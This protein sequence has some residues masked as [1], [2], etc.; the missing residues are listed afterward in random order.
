MDVFFVFIG[1][2]FTLGLK[3]QN[4]EICKRLIDLVLIFGVDIL[5]MIFGTLVLKHIEEIVEIQDFEYQVGVLKE[6]LFTYFT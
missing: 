6:K 1:Y 4:A 2:Y 3:D 5:K